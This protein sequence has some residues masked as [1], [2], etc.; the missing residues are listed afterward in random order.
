MA[1]DPSK[2]VCVSVYV[3][4]C[5]GACVPVHFQMCTLSRFEFVFALI[6]IKLQSK[7]KFRQRNKR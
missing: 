6:Q 1:V 7:Q 5:V 4:V 2:C 3:F